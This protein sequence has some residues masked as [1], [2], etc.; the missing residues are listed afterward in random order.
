MN[1]NIS[2]NQWILQIRL[3]EH[4]KSDK[5]SI[6]DRQNKTKHNINF[7]YPEILDKDNVKLMLQIR[8]TLQIKTQSAYNSLNQNTG[9]FSF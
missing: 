4:S 7:T 6:Y 9:S 1:F 3:S 2:L 5:S 8:E